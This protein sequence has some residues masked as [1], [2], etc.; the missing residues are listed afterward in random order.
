MSWRDGG[1]TS[2]QVLP[3]T[4]LA[5]ILEEGRLRHSRKQG[6]CILEHI[7]LVS[8]WK[9]ILQRCDHCKEHAPWTR[10]FTPKVGCPYLCFFKKVDTTLVELLSPVLPVISKKWVKWRHFHCH[11][12]SSLSA[13]VSGVG[14]MQ[15]VVGPAKWDVRWGEMGG[16]EAL[17]RPT[18]NA[19]RKITEL[20]RWNHSPS[21]PS[22][23]RS[24]YLDPALCV[25]GW[26]DHNWAARCNE[27]GD[28]KVGPWSVAQRF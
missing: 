12:C 27:L 22:T 19:S 11:P 10:I 7:L 13:T 3:V 9:V 28:F 5:H 14:H 20:A 26:N 15:Q 16:D 8:D 18:W 21:M 25:I 24:E 4:S 2:H 6:H 1:R 17:P 23:P